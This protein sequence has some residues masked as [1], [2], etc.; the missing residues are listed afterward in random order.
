MVKTRTPIENVKPS[1]GKVQRQQKE[2]S[3]D[4]PCGGYSSKQ[5]SKAVL[6]T[7]LT[8]LVPAPALTH[9]LTTSHLMRITRLQNGGG[10]RSDSGI[11]ITGGRGQKSTLLSLTRLVMVLVDLEL[12]DEHHSH[13]IRQQ[14][15]LSMRV[16]QHHTSL[17]LYLQ[18]ANQ[19][20]SVSLR[21]ILYVL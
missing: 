6:A 2:Q 4:G 8:A 5:A 9:T 13:T 12:D 16:A 19:P 15:L 3:N 21:I 14:R 18:S 17:D 20:E 1:G 10:G 7:W 11:M